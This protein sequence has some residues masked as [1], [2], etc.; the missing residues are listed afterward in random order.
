[1]HPK[2]PARSICDVSSSATSIRCQ[3]DTD[4]HCLVWRRVCEDD[5]VSASPFATLALSRLTHCALP[6]L[7][8]D[9]LR[10]VDMQED[11]QGRTAKEQVGSVATNVKPVKLFCDHFVPRSHSQDELRLCIVFDDFGQVRDGRHLRRLVRQ[12]VRSQGRAEGMANNM[13]SAFT[14]E[15]GVSCAPHP[16]SLVR[17]GTHGFNHG[18]AVL[19]HEQGH[20]EQDRIRDLPDRR[21]LGQGDIW[22]SVQLVEQAVGATFPQRLVPDM[23]NRLSRPC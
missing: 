2:R 12:D 4:T 1:M 6:S 18:L 8:R 15:T 3:Y 5:R 23:V 10:L 21:D 11:S 17:L 22:K 20:V 14:I 13:H 7:P 9:D 19:G 16:V